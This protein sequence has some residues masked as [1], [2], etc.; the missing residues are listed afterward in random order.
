MASPA[1]AQFLGG[2]NGELTFM[3]GPNYP[4][5]PEDSRT[6]LLAGLYVGTSGLELRPNVII[7]QG[8]V[9]GYLLDA[10]LR[11]TPKWFGQDEYLFNLISPY[12][13]L[14][15]S[16][17][18]PWSVGWNVKAGLGLALMQY[19]SVNAEIGYRSHRLDEQRLLEGLT[20]SVHAGYPF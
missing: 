5:D 14:G 8:Q 1:Q 17:A 3:R 4:N 2:V 19:I 9:D 10:G 11:V 18:Y 20:I 12:A 6:A 15:G 13:V 7:S 16:V